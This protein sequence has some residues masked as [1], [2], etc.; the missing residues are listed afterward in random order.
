MRLNCPYCNKKF[1]F[2]DLFFF[3]LKGYKIKCINCSHVFNLPGRIDQ[4]GIILFALLAMGLVVLF[5]IIFK[6]ISNY[7]PFS[8][9]VE[10]IIIAFIIVFVSIFII[11]GHP[12]YLVWNIRK[13]YEKD[14][15]VNRVRK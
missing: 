5:G 8:D 12:V 1:R 14:V 6:T 11:Y 15:G 10:M 9:T 2:L 13:K 4:F 7:F 3:R